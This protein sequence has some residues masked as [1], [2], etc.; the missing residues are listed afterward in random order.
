MAVRQYVAGVSASTYI[1][2][3]V[4]L[5]TSLPIKVVGIITRHDLTH[6][7]LSHKKKLESRLQQRLAWVQSPT[8]SP[9]FEP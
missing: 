3:M 1:P 5:L 2:D 7:G 8:T 9:G 4:T 6:E